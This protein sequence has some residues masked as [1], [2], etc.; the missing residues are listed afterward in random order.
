LVWVLG[1]FWTA[2]LTVNLFL[3]EDGAV[4]GAESVY[5]TYVD[6]EWRL[7]DLAEKESG[8]KRWALGGGAE[9]EA[10]DRAM[11]DL[12]A[13]MEAGADRGALDERGHQARLILALREG[14]GESIGPDDLEKANN[15]T[16]TFRILRSVVAGELVDENLL[17]ALTERVRKGD[18]D[19]WE[20]WLLGKAVDGVPVGDDVLAAYNDQNR[21]HG[22]RVLLDV[23]VILI[24]ILAGVVL[25]PVVWWK[26]RRTPGRREARIFERWGVATVFGVF[27]AAE[28]LA[29]LVTEVFWAG[30]SVSPVVVGESG[31]VFVTMMG[32]T[33]WRVLPVVAIV[34]FAHPSHLVRSMRLQPQGPVVAV[35]AM[36]SVLWLWQSAVFSL[37][38]DGEVSDPTDFMDSDQGGVA[39]TIFILVS[40]CLVA[41]VTE[42][43]MCRGVLFLG[44]KRHIGPW[45]AMLISSVIFGALHWQYDL[46]G[47]VGVS[48]MGVT[49]AALVWRTGSLFPSIVMH[50]LF[51]LIVTMHSY[52]IYHWPLR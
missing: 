29:D 44:L 7:Q 20:V 10:K 52:V 39:M 22:T 3:G 27:F 28:L 43:I 23:L 11:K 13:T 33:L 1:L 6:R 45:W 4:A 50:G 47:I 37:A 36:V 8:W 31:W 26:W 38:G 42:E 30:V 34:L 35:L 18:A 21:R 9:K 32:D 5:P 15:G 49:S 19:S 25:F 48:M 2:S 14:D 46:L 12:R 41:P 51:N 16:P 17:R 40:S 24:V